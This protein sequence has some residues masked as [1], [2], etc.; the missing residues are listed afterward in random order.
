MPCKRFYSIM[1]VTGLP[2]LFA[3][4][5]NDSKGLGWWD[6]KPDDEDVGDDKDED[7]IKRF[8]VDDDA[9]IDD[10]RDGGRGTWGGGGPRP[11][12]DGAFGDNPCPFAK[13]APHNFSANIW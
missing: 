2:W 6:V 1:Y 4:W 7:G 9:G 3:L 11:I 5:W 8:E 10:G 13:A 12:K